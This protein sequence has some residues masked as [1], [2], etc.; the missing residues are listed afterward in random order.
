MAKSGSKV[1]PIQKGPLRCD[2]TNSLAFYGNENCTAR[3]MEMLKMRQEGKTLTL[4][5]PKR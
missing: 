3:D 1:V 4:H 5:E 2:E